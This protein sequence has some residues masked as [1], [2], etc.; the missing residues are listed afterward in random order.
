MWLAK[1]LS[2][3]YESAYFIDRLQSVFLDFIDK[4]TIVFQH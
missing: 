1:L 4:A 3:G 2:I